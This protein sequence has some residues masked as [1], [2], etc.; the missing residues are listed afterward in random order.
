MEEDEPKVDPEAGLEE[1]EEGNEGPEGQPSRQDA[2]E[3]EAGV[4]GRQRGEDQEND[5]ADAGRDDRMDAD[6]SANP[7]PG[8]QSADQ[9]SRS[10]QQRDNRESRERQ[11]VNPHRK[12]GEAMERFKLDVSVTM[13]LENTEG[14][15][16]VPNPEDADEFGYD[17]GK[18]DREGGPEALGQTNEDRDDAPRLE[19]EEEDDD[20]DGEEGEAREEKTRV[21]REPKPVAERSAAEDRDLKHARDGEDGEKKEEE[22]GGGPWTPPTPRRRRKSRWRAPRTGRGR[23]RPRPTT[24]L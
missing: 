1:E 6:L 8:A 15:N 19:E 22:A 9:Q 17:A 11:G 14:A 21:A 4:G 20:G 23:R 12:F 10:R 16:E 7:Q 2:A 13:D 5:F 3:D 24:Q 18:E